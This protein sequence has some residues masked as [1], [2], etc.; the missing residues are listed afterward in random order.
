M[1]GFSNKTSRCPPFSGLFLFFF[2]LHFLVSVPLHLPPRCLD[3]GLWWCVGLVTVVLRRWQAA[4]KQAV[5]VVVAQAA[6]YL[7]REGGILLLLLSLLLYFVGVVRL[8]DGDGGRSSAARWTVAWV[9][10][11]GWGGDGQ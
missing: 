9:V 6:A 3:G 5:A 10:D 7:V 4:V 2:F 11:S 1:H 8:A